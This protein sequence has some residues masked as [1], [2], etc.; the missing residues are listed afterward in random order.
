MQLDLFKNLPHKIEGSSKVCKKCNILKPISSFRLYRRATGDRNSRD[1]KCKDC[2][3]HA[4]EV[5]KKLR[6][7]SPTP[8]G[9]CECCHIKTDK[10]VLDHCHDTEVFRGWLCP[11]C[12][13]GIGVLGDT[14]KGIKNALNYLN[15]T[16]KEI[17]NK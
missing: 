1:S 5:I 9:H 16:H 15:K 2:S 8:E 12:N 6:A 3:R 7:I 14:L 13:L 11:T 17:I 10:L 4:N